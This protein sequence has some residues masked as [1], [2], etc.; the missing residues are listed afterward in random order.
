MVEAPLTVA[1]DDRMPM[2]SCI[3]H[4]KQAEHHPALGRRLLSATVAI[5]SQL[6]NVTMD[7]R[8]GRSMAAAAARMPVPAGKMP[9]TGLLRPFVLIAK[10][11]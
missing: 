1:I 7:R 4:A 2:W 9:A 5:A 3:F 10:Q 6:L 11:N 8:Q